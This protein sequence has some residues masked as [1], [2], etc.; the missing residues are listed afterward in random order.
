VW[1]N[2]DKKEQ[3]SYCVH[4]IHWEYNLLGTVMFAETLSSGKLSYNSNHT[5]PTTFQ[6]WV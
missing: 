1:D 5:C 3:D 6:V 2:D 4:C